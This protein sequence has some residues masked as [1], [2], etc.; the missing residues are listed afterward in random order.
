M[1]SLDS[2]SRL[3]MERKKKKKKNCTKVIIN[4]YAEVNL[5]RDPLNLITYFSKKKK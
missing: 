5:I 2:I 3:P 1:T 4:I